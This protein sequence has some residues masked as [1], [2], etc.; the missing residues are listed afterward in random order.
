[1][2]FRPLLLIAVCGLL[3]LGQAAAGEA[4][5]VILVSIDGLAAYHL[6]N[7][8]LLLPNIRE[9][10]RHGAW[11]ASSETVF[12]SVTH[13][14][15][16]T[17]VTGVE[18]RIHGVLNNGMRHRETG[19]S[20]HPTNK[21]RTEIVKVPTLFDYAKR[22]G[23]TTAAF[24]WPETREDPSIDFNIPEVFDNR[25]RANMA[26]VDS[27]VLDELRGAGIPIDLY[28]RWYGTE[29]HGAGDAILAEA[30]GHALRKYRPNLLAIHF[31][32]TD[33]RQHNYGPHH[34]LSKAAL[35]D[36][37]QAVGILRQAAKS[38]GLEDAT[39]W[40]VTADHGFHSVY[41]EMNIQPVFANRGLLGKLNFGGY[42][43]N[44]GLELRANFDPATDGPKLEAALAELA[45]HD[46]IAKIV[47]PDDMHAMGQP[48]YE[49][50][51]YARAHYLV[52][53]DADTYLTTNDGDEKITR[54]PRET[55]SHTH[56]YL[57]EHPRMHTSL[58]LSG[59][60]I[61]SGVTGGHV[62]NLDIAPTIAELLGLDL[63]WTSGRV[64]DEALTP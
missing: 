20:F 32:I 16:T 31:L 24:F 57:P 56:G 22:K 52:I 49:E 33:Q 42:G 26:A 3:S 63:D 43:W 46:R 4:K 15:H 36:A 17:I 8:E 10:A 45:A 29:R 12:P 5:H 6:T 37:D 38:A 41:H 35:F 30:A 1:M 25:R 47:R 64:L 28:F 58:V 55:P 51:P 60:G 14:S 53:A 19:E 61:R 50:S 39:A 62:N 21:R 54:R 13:P 23:L 7:Q 34:Y 59:A 11:M 18:P 27:A 48:R 40:I 2:Y 44:L 9:L